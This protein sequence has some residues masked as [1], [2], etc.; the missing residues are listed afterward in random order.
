MLDKL[1]RVRQ[2]LRNA[3][4]VDGFGPPPYVHDGCSNSRVGRRV[5]LIK[6][7]LFPAGASL[8]YLRT[9]HALVRAWRAGVSARDRWD[10][11]ERSETADEMLDALEA[12]IAAAR[13][14]A[15]EPQL[16]SRDPWQD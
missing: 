12:A 2:G 5:D 4:P 13:G 6:R 7:D 9:L 8:A 3:T 10:I 14:E 1:R 16:D 11:V 15:V